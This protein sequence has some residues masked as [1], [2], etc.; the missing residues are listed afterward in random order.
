MLSD[1]CRAAR[2]ASRPAC[3]R[4]GV[5]VVAL[6]LVVQAAPAAHADSYFGGAVAFN[7]AAPASPY[8]GTI[9]V[10]T[11]E[12]VV[13]DVNVRISNLTHPFPADLDVLLVGPGGQSVMLLSDV[14][15]SA[16][17]SNDDLAFDDQAGADA[18]DPLVPGTYRPTNVDDGVA[19]LFPA[20]ASLAPFGGPLS[21]FNLRD[22]NGPWSIYALDDD[23]DGEPSGGFISWRPTLTGRRPAGTSESFVAVRE[24][25]GSARFEVH[26]PFQPPPVYAGAVSYVVEACP[27]PSA[28]PGEDFVPV[29]GRLDFA[30]GER[31]KFVDVPIVDD[32]VPEG[33]ECFNLRRFAAEVTSPRAPWSADIK[34]STTTPRRAVR[35]SRGPPRKGS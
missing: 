19:D 34:S 13:Q 14:G 11:T 30:A 10:N 7:D 23:A 18:P 6:A 12:T 20:P 8:P 24:G 4:F 32:H 35:A 16:A 1:S 15:P 31:E 17:S 22:P 21:A 33:S 3:C 28:L 27:T 26:R 2:R 29:S 9:V 25:S 5:V